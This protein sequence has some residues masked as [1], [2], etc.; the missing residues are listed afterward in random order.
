LVNQRRREGKILQS[1]GF[2]VD[3]TKKGGGGRG[4]GVRGRRIKSN[5][6]IGGEGEKRRGG[7]VEC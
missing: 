6:N 1:L 5:R 7:W 3:G 2:S 4:S